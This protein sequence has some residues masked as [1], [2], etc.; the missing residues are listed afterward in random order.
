M[1][2]S[3]RRIVMLGKTGAGKSSLANTIFGEEQ[4]KIDH[5]LNSGT[6]ECKAETKSVNGRNI[7]L[8]D[9]PSFFDTDRSEYMNCEIVRCITEC[10]PGPHAFLIVLKVEKVT[11][12]EQAVIKEINK[13]FSDEVFNYAT[14]VFTHGDQLPEGRKIEDF[15]RQNKF[16]NDLVKK[17]G[18]RCHVFDNRYWNNIPTND[19]RS[20]QF[21]VEELLKSI[22]KMVMENNGSC[23]TNEMLQEVEEEIQQEEEQIRLLPGDMSEKEIRELARGRVFHELWIKLA[24]TVTG[25]LL[26]ALFGVVVFVGVVVT[27]LSETSEPVKLR[28]AI[29]QT[30][31]AVGAALAGTGTA[32]V[33]GGPAAA[34]SGITLGTLTG[35][36]AAVGAVKGGIA[37][38][39]AAEGADTPREA[40]ERAA[41]AVKKEAQSA[42]DKGN[43]VVNRLYQT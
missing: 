9:T 17:C 1:D 13:C 18:S 31:K 36:S 43:D 26:G 11:E 16:M 10:A 40:A 22:D 24:G 39:Q 28:Q 27:S 41:E 23:Y 21:Q 30:A 20:N 2:V 25:T 34:V 35:V 15:V 6:G 32:A 33:A 7:T 4:F 29:S 12:Q 37:G 3:N 38:Y 42:L 14:V 8:I 5:T 19:Y